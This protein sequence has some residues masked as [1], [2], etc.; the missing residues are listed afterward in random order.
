MVSVVNDDPP[1]PAPTPPEPPKL[2]RQ[3]ALTRQQHRADRR[4]ETCFPKPKKV[5]GPGMDLKRPD[6][7]TNTI[8]LEDVRAHLRFAEVSSLRAP[9]RRAEEANA[10]YMEYNNLTATGVFRGGLIPRAAARFSEFGKFRNH[11]YIYI[12]MTA[13]LQGMP[14]RSHLSTAANDAAT[15][16]SRLYFPGEASCHAVDSLPHKRLQETLGD[17]DRRTMSKTPKKR[18]SRIL[19]R[20]QKCPLRSSSRSWSPSHT[21]TFLLQLRYYL[22]LL[23]SKCEQGTC[24]FKRNYKPR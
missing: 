12:Y 16:W 13:M 9:V 3:A 23:L 22:K 18:T 11:I 10:R 1:A 8:R 15:P 6:L 24:G 4:R 5:V 20:L 14:L 17:Q 7:M 19:P 21:K 2:K